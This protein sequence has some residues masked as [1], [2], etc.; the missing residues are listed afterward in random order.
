VSLW[1]AHPSDEIELGERAERAMRFS[2][3]ND[4][5][6]EYDR[7]NPR[8]CACYLLA[9]FFNHKTFDACDNDGHCPC[10]GCVKVR[11]EWTSERP[12]HRARRV[13]VRPAVS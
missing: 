6:A 5:S 8:R 2:F 3:L 10:V 9:V 12:L 1:Q 11:K 4:V 13:R 7:H